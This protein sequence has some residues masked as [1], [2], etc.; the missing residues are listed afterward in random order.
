MAADLEA[1][2]PIETIRQHTKTDDAPAVT[3]ALLELYRE[4]AFEAARLYTGRDWGA[5][6]RTITQV[7]RGAFGER[8]RISLAAPASDGLVTLIAGRAMFLVQVGPGATEIEIGPDMLDASGKR[9][10]CNPCTGV[11][12]GGMTLQF[13]TSAAA[14]AMP[15][16]VKLGALQFIAYAIGNPGDAADAKAAALASGALATW[17]RHN[18]GPFF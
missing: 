2:L 18:T 15:A 6:P 16:D 14:G 5:G 12:A 3:D 17:R 7:V 8:V 4:A 13:R 11:G 10:M 9:L 1:L